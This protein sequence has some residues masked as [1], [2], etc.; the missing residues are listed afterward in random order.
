MQFQN[1]TLEFVPFRVASVMIIFPR[2]FSNPKKLNVF[3]I[4]KYILYQK[5]GKL[6]MYMFVA[7]CSMLHKKAGIIQEKMSFHN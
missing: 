3:S 7:H 4:Y 6:G 2:Y 1:V 5:G